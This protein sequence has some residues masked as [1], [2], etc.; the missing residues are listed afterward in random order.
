VGIAVQQHLGPPKHGL[1]LGGLGEGRMPLK[2]RP[3]EQALFPEDGAFPVPVAG[4]AQATAVEALD[5]ELV[6]A[7]GQLWE[8]VGWDEWTGTGRGDA[9]Q[10]CPCK[11]TQSP[12]PLPSPEPPRPPQCATCWKGWCACVLWSGVRGVGN[13]ECRRWR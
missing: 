13:V 1:H 10:G 3:N 5:V 12:L 7:G 9:N 4:H 2:L 6:G 8:G 11:D